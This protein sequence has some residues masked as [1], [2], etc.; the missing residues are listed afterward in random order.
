[1][2]TARIIA[3][4]LTILGLA[5]CGTGGAASPA[6]TTTT[7][8][9]SSAATTTTATTADPTQAPADIPAGAGTVTTV[10]LDGDGAP[11]TLWLA[12][13][14]GA[15]ELGVATTGHGTQSVEF[16]SAAPQ[17]AVASAAVLAS[18][19]PV[20]FL[21]T[22]RSVQLYVYRVENPGLVPVDGVTGGQYSFSLGFTDYGTGLTCEELPDGLHL[23]GENATADAAGTWT[24][25]RTEVTVSAEH[26]VAQNGDPE[27]VGTGLAN[28]DPVVEAARGTTCGD[29][30]L[31]AEPM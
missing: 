7:T 24:V 4:P 15:R 29:A 23:Y 16:T 20:V 17:S 9:A 26:S 18:G 8:A 13:V 28:D 31:A 21:N 22:G 2:R 6:T 30:A 27:T 5:A 10:D 25:E 11:D 19:A 1:M 3:L 14:D 12:D